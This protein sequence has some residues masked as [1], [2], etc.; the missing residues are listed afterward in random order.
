MDLSAGTEEFLTK[1]D[2]PH[3]IGIGAADGFPRGLFMYQTLSS[4]YIIQNP[5]AQLS[6]RTV[7]LRNCRDLR[8]G[9]DPT[10]HVGVS[11]SESWPSHLWRSGL[12]RP[13]DPARGCRDQ[14]ASI[15]AERATPWSV[16]RVTLDSDNRK[17]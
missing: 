15:A 10:S 17:Q 2:G 3:T 7:S 4:N 14:L 8:T 13:S 9:S 12:V 16:N 11:I 5:S 1:T 6:E